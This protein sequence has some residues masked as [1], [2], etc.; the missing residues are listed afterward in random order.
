MLNT[1]FAPEIAT[2]NKFIQEHNY[3]GELNSFLH[4]MMIEG[5]YLM[6]SDRWSKVYDWMHDHYPE[7]TGSLITGITYWLES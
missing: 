2:A 1:N 3:D 7:A 6:H 4:S 5:A